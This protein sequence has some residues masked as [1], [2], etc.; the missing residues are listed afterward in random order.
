MAPTNFQ[1]RL[2]TIIREPKRFP[3]DDRFRPV[4]FHEQRLEIELFPR[5]E[6]RWN[7][8]RRR[9][10]AERES[11][12]DFYLGFHLTKFRVRW[13]QRENGFAD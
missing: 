9:H 11:T 8:Q 7:E 12:L 2:I 5:C 13:S 3:L 1:Q 10:R 6:K 4:I